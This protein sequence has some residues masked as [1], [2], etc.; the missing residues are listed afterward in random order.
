MYNFEE[1][2]KIFEKN[3]ISKEVLTSEFLA[4]CLLKDLENPKKIE[5]DY[6]NNISNFG[7]KTFTDT[8]KVINN[9]IK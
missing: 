2:Y 1:I 6:S 8:M 9:F 5:E 3:K 7:K 4:K